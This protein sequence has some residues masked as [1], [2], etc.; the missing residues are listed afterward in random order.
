MFS[1]KYEKKDTWIWEWTQEC[2][3]IVTSLEWGGR[4]I[5]KTGGRK[6]MF[7]HVLYVAVLSVSPH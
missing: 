4:G 1:K 6:K 2:L 5:L 7:T 3:V